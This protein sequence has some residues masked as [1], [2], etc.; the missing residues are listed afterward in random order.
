MEAKIAI[1]KIIKKSRVHLYKPIQIAEI[2]HRDRVNKDIDLQNLN[3]YRTQSK[4][5]RDIISKRFVGNVSTSSSVYQDNLFNENAVPP[6]LIAQLGIENC[7]HNGIVEAYIYKRFMQRQ[8]NMITSL[9]YA[10]TTKPQKFDLEKF[11]ELFELNAGLKRSIG[12][13]YEIIIYALF[14]VIVNHLNIR[15]QVKL[16]KSKKHLLK[17]FSNFAKNV[18]NITPDT[19][20]FEVQAK[21]HR[22]GVTNAADRGLDMWSNFGIAVQVKHL[23]LTEELAEGI[24]SSIS[25]DRIVIVCKSSQEKLIISLLNQ[26]GWK[27]KIQSVIVEEQLIDWY[28]KALRGTFSKSLAQPLIESISNQLIKEFPSADNQDLLN[29]MYKRGYTTLN[30]E[31]HGW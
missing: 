5:W 29:F 7:K 28:E 21:F 22:V 20:S 10:Q 17:E 8:S 31:I 4:K 15:V 19:T 11:I 25:A 26:I 24:V 14:S 12:K 2:L 13:V 9:D 27:S 1:D 3:T 18:L 30:T 23:S 6:R 16:D